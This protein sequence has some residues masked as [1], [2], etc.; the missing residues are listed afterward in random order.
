MLLLMPLVASPPALKV[1]L[2]TAEI[3]KGQAQTETDEGY[4]LYLREYPGGKVTR[5]TDHLHSG[6]ALGGSIRDATISPDGKRVLLM[7]SKADADPVPWNERSGYAPNYGMKIWLL[8]V[9]TKKLTL[10]TPGKEE[11]W[12][13][14]EWAPNGKRFMAEAIGGG[15]PGTHV[16]ETL[17]LWDSTSL[18]RINLV[19]ADHIDWSSWT[20]DGKGV[21]Y[22]GLTPGK[23]AALMLKS[24]EPVQP[25]KAIYQCSG[26][27]K[28]SAGPNNRILVFDEQGMTVIEKGQQTF[29]ESLPGL[30]LDGDLDRHVVWNPAGTKAAI[31]LEWLKKPPGLWQLDLEKGQS[32]LTTLTGIGLP[33]TWVGGKDLAL[34]RSDTGESKTTYHIAANGQ[35]LLD[36]SIPNEAIPLELKP[37][38]ER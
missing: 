3:P 8:D 10:V 32:P 26:A 9:D 17:Y 15:Q 6:D 37:V 2:L 12:G 1:T 35:T 4:D 28:V 33:L 30:R 5:L 14:M 25:P 23:P 13:R 22:R 7:A 29:R 20:A 11:A 31:Y 19:H 18:K 38:N 21:I 24:L 27:I 34:L 16:P 36:T